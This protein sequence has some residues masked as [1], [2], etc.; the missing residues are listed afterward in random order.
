MQRNVALNVLHSSSFRNF[1]R[2]NQLKT[3]YF[4]DLKCQMTATY[5]KV[6]KV[7][8]ED[9]NI[10]RLTSREIDVLASLALGKTTKEI[11]AALHL[12]TETVADY[13]KHLCKKLNLHSTA[14]L[15]AY[16]ISFTS[17]LKGD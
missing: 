16:A 10:P 12:S 4:S 7:M 14:S 5:G 8:R 1:K 9:H 15:V 3:S 6:M 13:R 11:A 2:K 17:T